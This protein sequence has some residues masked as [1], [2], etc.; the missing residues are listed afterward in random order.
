MRDPAAD[1]TGAGH[2]RRRGPSD[3]A[4]GVLAGVADAI[5]S[6]SA[7]VLEAILTAAASLSLLVLAAHA[8]GPAA[9]AAAEPAAVPI[10]FDTDI[11][12]DVDDVQALGLIH[13]LASR[14]EC[15]LL[16]VTVTKDHLLAAHLVAAINRFYG[17]PEIPVGVVRGGVTPDAGK[18]LPLAAIRDGDRL[19]YPHGPAA[20]GAPG[21]TA[22]AAWPEA[23][24]LLRRT[25]AARPDGSVTIVQVGFFTNLARLLDSPADDASP[26]PGREL[27]A[28]K[29]RLLSVMAGAF[30]PIDG[31]RFTEY[32][33]V[34]DLAPARKLA[35]EWPTPILWSGFEVGRAMPFPAASIDRDYRYV[36]HHPLAEAWK[37]YLPGGGD[38]PTWDLTSVLAVVRPDRGHFGLSPRGRVT[39]E[40]DGATTFVPE[41]EGRDRFLTVDA[42][43]AVRGVECFV[44]LCSEPPCGPH[45]VR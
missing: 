42:T 34:T 19:R 5:V 13:A 10:I 6:L 8:A 29:V 22:A 27:V 39:V 33:V 20:A 25:L 3:T 38:N 12:N 26:L 17:R 40:A 43:Q 15:E 16:A 7:T 21:A 11:G 2:S 41:A 37:L 4:A 36:E 24:G 44:Q 28:R 18:Y 14:G 9:A 35:A 1:P 45:H 23:V 30:Q 32:N 31:K